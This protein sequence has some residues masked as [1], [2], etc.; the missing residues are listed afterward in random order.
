[1]GLA[2]GHVAFKWQN[3]AQVHRGLL[4][5]YITLA[6]TLYAALLSFLQKNVILECS[7]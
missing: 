4:T 6:P 7:T 3:K 2:Q 5:L 1:M